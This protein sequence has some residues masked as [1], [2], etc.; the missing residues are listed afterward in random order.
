RETRLRGEQVVER[1]IVPTRTVGVRK[2]IADRKELALAIEEEREP[3][4]CDECEGTLGERFEF[5]ARRLVRLRR[6]ERREQLRSPI[7]HGRRLAG[8]RRIAPESLEGLL[9]PGN[10]EVGEPG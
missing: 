7:E 3:H 2:A 4:A 9:E 5:G 10:L 8:R 6:A 1:R